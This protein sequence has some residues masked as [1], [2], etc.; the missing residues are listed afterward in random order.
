MNKIITKT[1]FILGALLIPELSHALE[2][3]FEKDSSLPL[4]YVTAAFRGGSTQDPD[5][6]SGLS[7]LMGEMMLRGTKNK[8][9]QQLDVALDQLGGALEFETRS[10]FVAFRGAVL[11]ENLKPYLSLLAEVLTAPSFRGQELEKLK[12]ERISQLSDQLARDRDLIRLRFEQTLFQNHPYG[13][14]SAGKIKDIRNVSANDL[15]NQYQK[16]IAESTLV[17]LCR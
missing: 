7:N 2:F 11:S 1:A 17:M 12:K 6:K 16:L 5:G 9:K 8:T 13:R 4:V 14:P 3:Y 10:E 15:Q